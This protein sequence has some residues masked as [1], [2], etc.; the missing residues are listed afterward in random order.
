[1]AKAPLANDPDD[2][3]RP[4]RR[5]RIASGPAPMPMPTPPPLGKPTVPPAVA[6]KAFGAASDE[7]GGPPKPGS[8]RGPR[9]RR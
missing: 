5:T 4:E 8:L 9:R 2:A 3:S 7:H 1:M 6:A